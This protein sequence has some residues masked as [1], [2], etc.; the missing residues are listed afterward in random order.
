MARPKTIPWQKRVL[1]FLAHRQNG[2]K[3]YP[4][5]RKYRVARSTVNVIVNEFEEFG[6][7]DGPRARLSTDLLRQMQ[8]QHLSRMVSHPA[9][10]SWTLGPGTEN[11]TG[12]QDAFSNP[13]HI[14]EDFAWHIKGTSSEQVILEAI[15]AVRDYLTRESDAW[16]QLRS[17]LEERC[18]LPERGD[19]TIN[20]PE[21][22]LLQALRR[23]L[24]NV[25][26]DRSFQ[27][28]PPPPGW[29]EWD[30]S[31]NNPTVLRLR[32]ESVAVGD[33]ETH[34]RVQQGIAEFVTNN[35]RDHQRRFIEIERLRQDLGIMQGIL[36][37]SLDSIDQEVIR[38]GICPSCPYPEA[39]LDLDLT[40]RQHNGTLEEPD[41][42]DLQGSV[43]E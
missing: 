16:R 2:G 24:R 22:H 34:R 32:R 3:V 25:I 26:F 1:V 13:L 8:E 42:L 21:P 43:T 18:G 28:D 19:D 4:I 27:G 36:S 31:P 15:E 6:F 9:V 17:D 35:F 11:E 39:M 23:Q 7:S 10:G 38:R 40:L 37:R 30:T 14:D 20:D 12:R 29:L 33:S 41:A 5:A